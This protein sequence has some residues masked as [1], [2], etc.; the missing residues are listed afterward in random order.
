VTGYGELKPRCV[1]FVSPDLDIS[2]VAQ[3]QQSYLH[4]GRAPRPHFLPSFVSLVQLL[5]R[6]AFG[7]HR[8]DDCHQSVVAGGGK[9][10]A[11]QWDPEAHSG[12][13]VTGVGHED[14]QHIRNQ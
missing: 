4:F 10:E 11:Q 9:V 13:R 5:L 8:I 1:L 2:I 6:L 7:H 12:A 14:L 3:G